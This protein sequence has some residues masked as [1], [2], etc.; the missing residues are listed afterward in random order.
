MKNI[1]FPNVNRDVFVHFISWT[2]PYLQYNKI[3]F[4][5]YGG[6]SEI[7]WQWGNVSGFLDL[8]KQFFFSKQNLKKK[9]Q[10]QIGWS[11]YYLVNKFIGYFCFSVYK[12]RCPCF[13][14][15][16]LSPPCN[17]LM[18]R[19]GNSSQSSSSLNCPNKNWFKK[20]IYILFSLSIT[21]PLTASSP[22]PLLL[23]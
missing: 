9:M 5:K 20:K 6:V 19:D 11:K 8:S 3:T 22:N 10:Y 14:V 1:I 17:F 16:R 15:C 4:R 23:S 7:Y 18:E 12:L 2:G 13:V 21:K